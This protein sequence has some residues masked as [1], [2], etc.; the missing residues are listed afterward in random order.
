MHWTLSV[1]SMLVSELLLLVV[2]R[3]SGTIILGG[4][5]RK[6]GSRVVLRLSMWILHFLLCSDLV[7]CCFEC[8]EMLC[9][10]DRLLVSMTIDT[11]HSSGETW[12]GSGWFGW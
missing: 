12:V 10:V 8:R 1:L 11:V 7:S 5:D 4:L 9:L 6:V 2:L 3:I